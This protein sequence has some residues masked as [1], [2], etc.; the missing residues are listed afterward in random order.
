MDIV[1]SHFILKQNLGQWGHGYF[2]NFD[3]TSEGL[4]C[5]RKKQVS[6]PPQAAHCFET[7]DDQCTVQV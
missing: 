4:F 1:S 3:I 6:P 5:T 7:V 2:Q